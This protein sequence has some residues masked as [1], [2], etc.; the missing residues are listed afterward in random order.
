MKALRFAS[1]GN[2]GAVLSSVKSFWEDDIRQFV[3]KNA[4]KHLERILGVEFKQAIGCGKYQRTEKRQGQRNGYYKRALLTLYGWIEELKVPRL[5]HGG[6]ESVVLGRYC[7][8]TKALDRLILEG[9]LLGHSTR[10]TV[11]QFRKLLG[12]GFSPQAVSNII[13][14]LKAEVEA[15]HHRRMADVYRVLYLDGLWIKIARPVKAKMV[16][17]VAYGYRHDG[18]K[19][20]LD[21]LLAPSE[22]EGSWWGLI[23]E[24]KGRGLKGERLEACV[25][26]GCSGLR[27][28]LLALYPRVKQQWCVF[29]KLADISANLLDRRNRS[30]IAKDAAAIY[31]TETERE[32]WEALKNF[33]TR[34]G[35]L[36]PKAVRCF[37]RGFEQTLTYREFEKPIKTLIRTNNPIERPLEELQRR[38]KP[39]RK[40]VN[41]TSAEKIIYGLVAYVLD[42]Q[43]EEKNS[44]ILHN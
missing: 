31:E 22:S 26:D 20:L 4:R 34:W 36:E 41:V 14:A 19:E 23:S 24:L 35:L 1:G 21:F 44:S 18:T 28:A 30:K 2:V 42:T 37:V 25:H 8:R 32:L 16:L 33:K 7:R 13:G 29:H 27:K 6:W 10:K 5:R 17:L 38:I 15:F 40:F 11:R 39:F 3:L 9:F 12:A 43:L